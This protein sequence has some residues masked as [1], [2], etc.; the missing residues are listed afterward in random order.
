MWMKWRR[1]DAALRLVD[2]IV[3]KGDFVIDIGAAEGLY[4]ARLSQLVG[5]KGRVYAFEPNPVHRAQLDGLSTD[6]TNVTVYGA[7]LSDQSGEAELHIPV[8]HDEQ[9]HGLGSI[10]V[11]AARASVEHRVVSIPLKRLDDVVSADLPPVAFVKCD[12]EG[13]ELA[14]LHGAEETLRRSRP[15]V[16]IEIE[17]RHQDAD[18]QTTFDHFGRLGYT[19]YSLHAG[20]LRPLEEFRVERD[21]L[22]LLG[23][24]SAEIPPSGYIH[25]FLFVAPDADVSRL[26][27]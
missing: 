19:G 3:R 4:S 1:T 23:P 26:L 27:A 11:P 12:V 15:T 14:V 18:I 10:S 22:A 25:N 21:Q 8:V 24:D 6:R 7:G 9:L 5:R 20:G 2:G 16:F 17:Q 13:H